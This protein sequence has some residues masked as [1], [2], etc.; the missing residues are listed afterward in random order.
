M[1]RTLDVYLPG[2]ILYV[3]GTVNG[4]SVTWTQAGD[5][6]QAVAQRSSTEIYQVEI[7]AVNALGTSASYSMTLYYGLHLVTDRTSA[8][9]NRWKALRAKGWAAMTEAEQAEWTAGMKGSYN[10][11]DFSR[12]EDAIAYLKSR[13]A[14]YGYTVEA[15]RQVWVSGEIPDSGKLSRYLASLKAVRNALGAHTASLPLPETMDNLTWTDANNMEKMLLAVDET[16]TYLL[17]LYTYS[18]EV[19][20][21]E[22][23]LI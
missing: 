17:Q 15:V 8:D 13:L 23:G 14:R 6:W 4:E 19:Q 18:G 16:L 1:T 3:S 21:G 9:V 5:A 11:T 7:T 2:N 12:V 20:A 10:Y 22:W